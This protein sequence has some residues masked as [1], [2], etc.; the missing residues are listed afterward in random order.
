MMNAAKIRLSPK[1]MEL[2][3]NAEW[4]LTKNAII[5]KVKHLLG[6]LSERQKHYI[7]SSNLFIPEAVLQPSAKIS[8]GENYKGLPYLILDYPRYFDKE[9]VYAIRS[10][11][12]WGNFFS[13]TLHLSGEYK[14]IAREKIIS[15]YTLLKENDFFICTSHN[16][17]EHHFESDN[18][19]SLNEMKEGQFENIIHSQTFLKLSQKIPLQQWD[20]V[21]EKLL[22]SFSLIIKML[23]A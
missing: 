8:K 13:I 20:D 21:P 3:S 4:I 6:L 2:V 9:N 17:W 11:F 14:K 7:K 5:E 1:E 18:Y 10:M 12:W 22:S 19:T 23:A 15:F 16:Q